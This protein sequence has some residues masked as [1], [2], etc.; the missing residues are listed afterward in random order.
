MRPVTRRSSNAAPRVFIGSAG[1]RRTCRSQQAGLLHHF[2]SKLELIAAL[3]AWRDDLTRSRFGTTD[4]PGLATIRALVEPVE[5]NQNTPTL[6]GLRATLSAE[7]TTPGHP[8]FDYFAK[9]Y[10]WVVDFTR[11]AFERAAEAGQLR[12]GVE[13]ESAAR[14]A[15]ALMDG[16]QSQWLYDQDS[17][18]MAAEVLAHIGALLTVEL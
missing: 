15:I 9:R 12:P 7:A 14:A 13:P 8:L 16:L 4:L 3:L 1:R 17:V 6:V 10:A 2:P 11:G 5:H 18:D